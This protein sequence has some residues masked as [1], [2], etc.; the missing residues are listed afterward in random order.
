MNIHLMKDCVSSENFRPCP[1]CKQCFLASDV[2]EHTNMKACKVAPTEIGALSCPLCTN[3]FS[4]VEL[5]REHLKSSCQKN[6]RG[7]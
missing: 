1:R 6:P 3:P 5:L 4:N 2:K 7:V